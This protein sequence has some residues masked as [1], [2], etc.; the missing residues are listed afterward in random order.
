MRSL[1]KN[2]R[3]DISLDEIKQK[4]EKL[5]SSLDRVQDSLKKHQSQTVPQ[6]TRTDIREIVQE[7][8]GKTARA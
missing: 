2:L 8:I 3:G 4:L 6:V 1:E 5:V 7:W